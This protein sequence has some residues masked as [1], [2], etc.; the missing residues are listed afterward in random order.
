[1]N[2]RVPQKITSTKHARIKFVQALHKKSLR[3]QE[4]LFTIEGV[5]E[6]VLA[7]DN[8]VRLHSLFIH[9]E[10]SFESHLRQVID[11]ALDEMEEVN[12]MTVTD[13]VYQSMCYR[14]N[15]ETVAIAFKHDVKLA[16]FKAPKDSFVVICSGIEK[17][18]N[19]GAVMR[20][21]DAVGVHAII[22]SDPILDIFNPNVVRASIGTFFT[23]PVI[24]TDFETVV[25]WLRQQSIDLIATSPGKD[26]NYAEYAYPNRVAI[27][28]GNEAHGLH[29]RWFKLAQGVV[30][31]PQLGQA[32]S[33]NTA[34]S[35]TVVL[36]EILRQR[37]E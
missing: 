14:A 20:S 1:M 21:A 18:G 13:S 19:L 36:F 32:D 5:K 37:S 35:A 12:V 31:I 34:M 33:L 30:S 7:V 22:V 6:L 9:E 24:I 23:T 27:V 3:D 2:N 16:D 8:G 11:R 10:C 29:Q 15:S 4:G 17:P 25:S 28:V 26:M